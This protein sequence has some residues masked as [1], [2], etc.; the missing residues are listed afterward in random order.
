[1]VYMSKQ[2]SEPLSWIVKKY[3][4]N[5]NVIEDYNV[6]KYREDFV[7]KLKKKYRDKDT[8]AKEMKSEMMY[9]YWSGC[10]YELVMKY[11]ESGRVILSPR[12][13]CRNPEAVEIDVTDNN[14]FDW[15]G[16]AAENEKKSREGEIVI[17]IWD[18]IKYRFDD[19]INYCREY[20]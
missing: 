5:K 18:Q 17:D 10:E 13:G 15:K 6:F 7:K 9:H 11:T 1:M 12:I 14:D 2:K 20:K 4:F 3:D 19:F 16:F 8:F